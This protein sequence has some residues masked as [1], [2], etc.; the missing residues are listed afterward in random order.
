M[1]NNV[2]IWVYLAKNKEQPNFTW[3]HFQGSQCRRPKPR[4]PKAPGARNCVYSRGR[5]HGAPRE[6]VWAI[7]S[8]LL[9]VISSSQTSSF[10]SVHKGSAAKV[11][12]SVKRFAPG[13][14]IIFHPDARLRAQNANQ[15][16][17]S[18]AAN[19]SQHVCVRQTPLA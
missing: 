18:G 11:F 5:L 17:P 12:R 14:E 13:L 3:N 9:L 7:A 6:I 16:M 2:F 10:V 8:R 4:V 1:E 15:T 19:G